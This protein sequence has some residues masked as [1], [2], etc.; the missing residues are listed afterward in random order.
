MNEQASTLFSISSFS[1][2]GSSAGKVELSSPPQYRRLIQTALH[3]SLY[4]LEGLEIVGRQL[5][6]I[7]RQAYFARQM[8]TVEHA[9]QLMLALP[10][11]KE[12][13]SVARYYQ[14]LYFKRRGDFT[15]TC[16]LLELAAKESPPAF[17]AR[18]LLSIGATYFDKFEIEPAL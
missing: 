5:A 8:E 4:R 14:A 12:L 3:R 16:E 13:K 6:A 10:L 18:V 7:A 11:S 1:F 9:S 2:S 15:R 17:R